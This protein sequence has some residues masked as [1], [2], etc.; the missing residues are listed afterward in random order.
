VTFRL[1]IHLS[2]SAR[3]F[4]VMKTTSS[5]L[6]PVQR[7]SGFGVTLPPSYPKQDLSVDNKGQLQTEIAM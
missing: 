1:T 4:E 7:F 3:V 6:R 2:E 5:G